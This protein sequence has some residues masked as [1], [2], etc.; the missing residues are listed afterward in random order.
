MNLGWE[1]FGEFLVAI[2]DNFLG[3]VGGG[4]VDEWKLKGR[5]L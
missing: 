2:K 1:G 4:S 3:G 5:I